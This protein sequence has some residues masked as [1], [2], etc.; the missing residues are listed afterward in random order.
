LVSEGTKNIKVGTPIAVVVESEKDVAAFK[1]YKASG[2]SS[3]SES[4]ASSQ[5]SAEPKE[6][7][8]PKSSSSGSDSAAPSNLPTHDKVTMPA[9]SPTMKSGR[10]QKWHKQEG[11][12]ITAGDVLADVET[13]KAT[14]DF[15]HQ[16]DGYLAK[17]LVPEGDQDIDVGQLVAIVVDSKSDIDAFKNVTAS[18]LSG[19]SAPAKK[20]E[21]K[22]EE[23]K[24]AEETKSQ[25]QK[26]ET[27]AKS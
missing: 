22:K 20:E 16:E 23:P 27:E 5:K 18:Q 12:E 11:D 8:K 24:K 1:D 13:D 26:T 9:L 14:I 4:S 6:E 10:I 3:G 15:V 17:I 25:P 19:G 2:A 7:S 21:P